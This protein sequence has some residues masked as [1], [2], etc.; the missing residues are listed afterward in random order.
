MVN[1]IILSEVKLKELLVHSE[2]ALYK[3]EY[4]RT[5]HAGRIHVGSMNPWYSEPRHSLL[6]YS[7]VIHTIIQRALPSHRVIQIFGI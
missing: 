7:V 6:A 1:T 5:T 3:K 4:D 2:Q